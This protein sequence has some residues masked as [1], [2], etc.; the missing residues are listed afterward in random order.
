MSDR[1]N[2]Q[3]QYD[4]IQAKEEFESMLDPRTQV[5]KDKVQGLE[6]E[7]KNLRIKMNEEEVIGEIL[8]DV[9]R[10]TERE[11]EHVEASYA[12][13]RERTDLREAEFQKAL[14]PLRAKVD[15]LK[16]RFDDE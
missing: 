7:N 6:D 5:L 9:L 15:I 10:D 4:V 1:R 8:Y 2:N 11:L 12:L 13:F 3:D 16:K 14:E